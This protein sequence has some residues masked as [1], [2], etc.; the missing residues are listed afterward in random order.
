MAGYAL[1][2]VSD[3]AL[4]AGLTAHLAG[5]RSSLAQVLAHLGEVEARRLYARAGYS[6]MYLYCVRAL[7]LSEDA[8]CRRLKAARAARAYPAIFEDIGSGRLTLSVVLLLEPCLTPGT[9]TELL[10]AAAG[11]SKQQTE[12]LLA[13]RFPRPDLPTLLRP[14][15]EPAE[16]AGATRALQ[17]ASASP[18][19]DVRAQTQPSIGEIPSNNADVTTL[20]P[21]PAPARV[22]VPELSGPGAS[23]QTSE[24]SVTPASHAR[25]APRSPGR[26]ALQV[27]IPQGTCDKLRRAQELL[28]AAGNGRDVA[29]VLDRALAL[30]VR[31]LEQKRYAAT[32]RPRPRPR[33]S[34]A[35]GRAIPAQ[36]KREVHAR[37]GGQ[38]TFTSES[39]RRCEARGALEYDHIRPVARGGRTCTENLRLRCRAHNQL[40]AEN[41]YGRGFMEEKRQRR[42]T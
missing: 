40:E 12:E 14:V 7:H 22:Q 29:Q 23:T 15:V 34:K 35:A 11:L 38:C 26:F 30:L 16:S 41:T 17:E 24:R 9:A 3:H 36:V 21:V 20:G 28:G 1:T 39:G 8:A 6:S 25:V 19:P 5:E 31:Q 2:Q 4:L 18:A 32:E 10:A 37:D 33:R 42:G 27:T 13:A